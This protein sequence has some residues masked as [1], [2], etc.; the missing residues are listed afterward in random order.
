M[1]Q[2]IRISWLKS[3]TRT[4][5]HLAVFGNVAGEHADSGS[6]GVQQSQRKTLLVG[7]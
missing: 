4:L 3:E 7:G 2:I 1:R 6:H 5:D